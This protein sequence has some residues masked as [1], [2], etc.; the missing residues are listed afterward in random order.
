M[1]NLSETFTR[2]IPYLLI[3]II[4]IYMVKPNILFKP[5]GKPRI[6]G[7]GIDEEGYKKT[8]FTFQF[9]IIIL[10]LLVYHF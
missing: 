5:N 8:L 3:A 9:V 2:Q 7:I 4:L 6:Y 10:S 1:L